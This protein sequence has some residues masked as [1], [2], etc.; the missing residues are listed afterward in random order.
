MDAPR[1]PDEISDLMADS[2]AQDD[3]KQTM[4]GLTKLLCIYPILLL[5]SVYGTWIATS[6]SLGRPPRFG[7]TA[8]NFF[9]DFFYGFANFL[10]FGTPVC[11]I[12]IIVCLFGYLLRLP[13]AWKPR[14]I[15][16]T[17]AIIVWISVIVLGYMP[18]YFV[19]DWF[20]D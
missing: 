7:E 19:F 2:N 6:I 4:A 13:P 14:I 10:L 11:W 3:L 8:D 9:A 1:Q 12:L 16:L 15:D 5:L 18:P 17:V 20:L